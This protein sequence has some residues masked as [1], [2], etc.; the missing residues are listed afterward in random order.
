MSRAGKF[1]PGG[2]NKP[3][4][5]AQ[6]TGPIR[7]PVPGDTEAAGGPSKKPA[8]AAAAPLGA[9]LRKPVAKGQ[10]LPIVIMSA[11]VCCLLVSFAWYEFALLPAKREAEAEKQ[12]ADDIQKQLDQA[13]K[14]EADRLAA[15]QAETA[16]ARATLTIN[17]VPPGATVTIGDAHMQTPATFADLIPG[18][19]TVSLKLDGYED[20]KQQ[21]IPVTAD[22]PT[23]LG[24]ITLVQKAGNLSI[25][26]PQ[27]EVQY[28]L[29]GPGDYS[30]DGNVP[31]VLEKLPIGD[32]QL[33]AWQ[34]D[35]KLAPITFTIHDQ[36]TVNKEIKFPYGSITITS[37]PSGATVRKDHTIVGK[38]PYTL[39]DVRPADFNFSVDLPPYTTER[40]TIH[41][42]EFGN[43]NKVVNL[44]QGKD[45][46]ASCG[47]P[48][49]WIPD[50]GFW[51]GKYDVRQSDYETV[52]GSNP[53][54]FRR[55]NRPVEQISWEAA[56]AFCDKL[57]AYEKKA[58]KLPAGFHYA[59]PTESQWS[60]YSA[61]ADINQAAMSR[62][63]TLS[64]T[65]DVGASEP[66]KY[67]LYDT[68]GNVWEWSSDAFDEKG[69]H[70]LRG[71]SW[72]SSAENFPS[73]DTRQGA[74]PKYAD[75]FIGFRVVLVPN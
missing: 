12:H 63:T 40:F 33:S 54:Y 9:S 10:K 7:A 71:G 64:S 6:R 58:G 1:I 27:T 67:G 32:Y 42:P 35:W 19:V 20:Y 21:D 38:T 69:N 52:A 14:D 60:D 22:K 74:G 45:F 61:D 66:N 3:G 5:P 72:L 56:T 2:G 65:Q 4:D 37:V 55:P 15:Q 50:G 31:D 70:S 57:T 25:T 43:I 59:L 24:T 29:T 51:A 30:H 26:S 68:L 73:S 39:T 8:S 62:G 18:K 11:V 13:K 47:M 36:E 46:I 53:S 28:T 23:D 75:R 34:H 44:Q 17:S 16:K 48:M 49:V 41:V